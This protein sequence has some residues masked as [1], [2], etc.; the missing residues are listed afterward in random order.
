[1]CVPLITIARLT[2]KDA[3]INLSDTKTRPAARRVDYPRCELMCALLLIGALT[4][5]A[6]GQM[7]DFRFPTLIEITK[8][9]MVNFPQCLVNKTALKINRIYS[10]NYFSL[11]SSP[12]NLKDKR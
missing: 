11:T 7:I 9:A 1:V 2:D 6:N 12:S 8:A 5:L 3:L 10:R 4:N